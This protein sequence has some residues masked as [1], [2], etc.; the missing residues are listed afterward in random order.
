VFLGGQIATSLASLTPYQSVY[1]YRVASLLAATALWLFVY[2]LLEELFE[3]RDTAPATRSA[4]IVL[5]FLV[6]NPMVGYLTSSVTPDAVAIPLGALGV[7]AC[8]RTLSTGT[9]AWSATG[10]LLLG[11][12]AKPSGVQIMAALAAVIVLLALTR[13]VS[14]PHALITLGAIGRAAIPAWLLFYAWSPTMFPGTPITLDLPTYILR[15]VGRLPEFWVYLWGLLG[16]QD[17]ALPAVWYLALFG[18]ALV[19]AL[20]VWRTPVPLRRFCVFA[21]VF[22]V[23]FVGTLAAGEFLYLKD[24]GYILRGRYFLPALIG[25]APLVLHRVRTA[26]IALLAMLV[27]MNLALMHATVVRCYGG[28]YATLWRAMPFLSS[29]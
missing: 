15:F 21:A 19:N 3:Q 1:A 14:G 25:L 13:R 12:L 10:W 2:R 8:W 23:A 22:F 20:C 18:V 28:D 9:R 4:P 17:Y 24:I 7:L 11:A 6:L 5:A 27:C 29:R 16:W 26:R